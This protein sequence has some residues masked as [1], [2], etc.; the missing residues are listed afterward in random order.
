V[1]CRTDGGSLKLV[2]IAAMLKARRFG[3]R[4]QWRS[5]AGRERNSSPCSRMQG[6]ASRSSRNRRR[7]SGWW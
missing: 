4:R 2:M 1:N 5:S 3:A 6:P 7:T